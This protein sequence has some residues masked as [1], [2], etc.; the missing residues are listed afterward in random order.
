MTARLADAA[1]Y[2]LD[3]RRARYP[4]AISEGRIAP[5]E[6][7]AD[8]DAWTAI[9]ALLRTG[10]CDSGALE[11][12]AGEGCMP[13]ALWRLLEAAA[14]RAVAARSEAAAARPA[15]ELRAARLHAA[16]AIHRRMASNLA[17]S[18]GPRSAVAR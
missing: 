17:W 4:D 8:L 2:E 15:D 12:L 1:R 6:A 7:A 5:D 11:A 18:L 10:S 9:E 3:Q 13:S 16:E 14:A